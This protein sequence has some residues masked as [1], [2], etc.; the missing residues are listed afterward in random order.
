MVGK[1]G[2]NAYYLMDCYSHKLTQSVPGSQL[3]CFYEKEK[4]KDDGKTSEIQPLNSDVDSVESDDDMSSTTTCQSVYSLPKTSTPKKNVDNVGSQIV[5]ISG[6]ELH[7]SSD[8]SSTCT[9]NVS[10]EAL[11]PVNPWGNMDIQDIPIE[12]V[13]HFS[14]LEE[15]VHVVDSMHKSLFSFK[16]LTDED[17]Q[18][19][20]L[21][22]NLV[23]NANSH[24]VK[25]TGIGKL[26]PY[27]PLITQEAK[28]NG[29]CL[30]NRFSMLL[31]GRDTYS[32]IICHIVCNYISN[33]VKYKWLQMYL[34]LKYKNGKDYVV[35]SG[36]HNFTTWGTE[37]E[38]IAL[39]Q[40]SGFD[41]YI[42][43]QNNDWLQYAS[44]IPN[45]VNKKSACAFYISNKS[46]S[47]FNPVFVA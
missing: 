26:C 20:A 28:P 5:I 30:F 14:D 6:K 18:I 1:S 36:M 12:I 27:L 15:S 22:F 16:P 9:I 34:A 29:A 17:R 24:P 32:T 35:A 21:E 38:I 33:P 42:Y 39:A 46:G 19:C 23:I 47:H 44:C 10:T 8:D 3:V 41:I 25:F 2:A 11:S 37:V 45:G 13:D 43:T 31:A 40:I 7:M 4:Y